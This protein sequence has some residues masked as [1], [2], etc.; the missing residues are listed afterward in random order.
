LKREIGCG[1]WLVWLFTALFAAEWLVLWF[2]I[3]RVSEERLP[4]VVLI[5]ALVTIVAGWA[6]VYIRLQRRRQ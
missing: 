4:Q 3:E 5:V 1:L 2:V 6:A